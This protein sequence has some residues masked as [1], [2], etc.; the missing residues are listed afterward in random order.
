MNAQSNSFKLPQTPKSFT[1][2]LGGRLGVAVHTFNPSTREA[3]TGR[4]EFEASLD[5]ITWAACQ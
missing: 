4:S 3:E 2:K 1:I 5:Y